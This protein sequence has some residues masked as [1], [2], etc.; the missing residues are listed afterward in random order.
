MT[1]Q[2]PVPHDLRRWRTRHGLTQADAAE[3]VGVHERSWRKW[4]LEERA[5]PKMLA[6]L[7]NQSDTSDTDQGDQ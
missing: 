5:I 2:R 4:E 3:V 7:V 1:P 6:L